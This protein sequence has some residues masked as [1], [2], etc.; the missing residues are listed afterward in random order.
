[1]DVVKRSARGYLSLQKV[2]G[3]IDDTQHS[4]SPTASTA[5]GTHVHIQYIMSRAYAYSNRSG[6]PGIMI[7]TTST[8]TIIIIIIPVIYITSNVHLEIYSGIQLSTLT[9]TKTHHAL[10]GLGFT[11]C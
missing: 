11:T 8:T 7:T 3:V 1:M 5:A 6:L 2:P 4:C 10:L 9:Y